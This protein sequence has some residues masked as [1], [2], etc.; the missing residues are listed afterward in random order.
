MTP[1]AIRESQPLFPASRSGC[2]KSP[3]PSDPSTFNPLTFNVFELSALRTLLHSLH[4]LCGCHLLWFLCDADSFAKTGGEGGGDY[5][6]G[7][8][9]RMASSLQLCHSATLQLCNSVSLSLCHL[10]SSA[11]ISGFGSPMDSTGVRTSDCGSNPFSLFYFLFSPCCHRA[12][13]VEK[14]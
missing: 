6:S 5:A 9:A 11:F 1:V 2:A 3:Y 7:Q 14:L 8:V 4:A 10:R 13:A 12:V